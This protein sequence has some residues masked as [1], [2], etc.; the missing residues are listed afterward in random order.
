MKIIWSDEAKA[1]FVDVISDIE[2][3]FTKKESGEFVRKSFEVLKVIEKFPKIYKRTDLRGM[4]N[5][6]QA[7]IHPH[8]TLFYELNRR[9]IELL[10]FWFN[11]DDPSKLETD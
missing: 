9:S 10:F 4:K 8:T 7:V 2:K 6:R 3:N 1:T 5:V 11:K